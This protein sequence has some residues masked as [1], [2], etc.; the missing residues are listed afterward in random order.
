MHL[1]RL[2]VD[3][4]LLVQ[5]LRKARKINKIQAIEKSI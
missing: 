4:F 2:H 1:V 3:G 5:S